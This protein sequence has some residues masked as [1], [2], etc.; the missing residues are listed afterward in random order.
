MTFR[1]KNVV[2]K[3]YSKRTH[4]RTATQKRPV[5]VATQLCFTCRPVFM[6]SII[7][8]T[9]NIFISGSQLII[10]N[11]ISAALLQKTRRKM[12][13]NLTKKLNTLVFQ[14]CENPS[15]KVWTIFVI[16]EQFL[17]FVTLYHLVVENPQQEAAK[18]CLMK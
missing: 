18:N 6:F 14:I 16:M 7:T 8:F 15:G 4:N 10:H 12:M 5:L 13:T 9:D 11:K 3:R 17:N 2:R 1:Y